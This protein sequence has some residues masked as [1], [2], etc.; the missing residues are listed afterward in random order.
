[1]KYVV[2]KK[3]VAKEFWFVEANS[4]EEALLKVS[5]GGGRTASVNLEFEGYLPQ[6]L[7]TVKSIT[8]EKGEEDDGRRSTLLC[9]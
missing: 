5:T 1:M 9:D 6:T 4:E 3:V 2:T 8:E 7:W